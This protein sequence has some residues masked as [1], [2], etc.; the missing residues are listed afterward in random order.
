MIK[1][2]NVLVPIKSQN[3]QIEIAA[4]ALKTNIKNKINGAKEY[5]DETIVELKEL[6]A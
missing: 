3:T 2:Q 1:L 4:N 5:I 6:F